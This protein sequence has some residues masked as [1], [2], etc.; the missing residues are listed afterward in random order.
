[1]FDYESLRLI[2]WALLG[3][4][5]I[6]F[7][8]MDGFDF[9][10]AALLRVLG[11]TDDERLVLLETIEPTWEGNQVWFVLAGGATFAAWPQLYAVSFSGM[12]LAI[13]LVLVAL[14]LRPVGFNFRGK[15]HD[16][17]WRALWDGVLIASGVVVMLISG[18][19][20]G[21][22]FLGVPFQFDNDLRMSWHGSFFELLHPFAL[23]AG[24]VSLSMLLAHGACWA[25]YKADHVV[26]DRAVRI[27]RWATLAYVLFYILAGIWLAY[28]VPGFAIAGPVV[29][30]GVSNPLYKQV[31]VGSSWFASYMQHPWFWLAPVLGVV[32]AIGVQLSVARKNLACFIWSSLMVTG[33]ILSAGFALFPFLLPSRLDP[34]SS[35]TVWDA[36]SSKGTLGLMLAMAVIFMPIIIIYT[37]WVYRVVRG[38]VTLEHVR[39]SGHGY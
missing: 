18:V 17:R 16:P 2:W 7:A 12:Y 24:L 35:L 19:A 8:I 27:A 26:A 14:I 28:G 20:F 4:L 31:A 6:G 11:R 1:M 37:S 25:A 36:S 32:G 33:T 21:N 3:I 29:T 34:R 10:I 13:F 22:L 15:V 23:V 5:F 9:G 38:R 30:D 39:Q